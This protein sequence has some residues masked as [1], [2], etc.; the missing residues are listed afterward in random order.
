M[1]NKQQHLVCLYFNLL[2]ILHELIVECFVVQIFC[3]NEL[4][5]LNIWAADG[6]SWQ[7]ARNEKS[8]KQRV[9]RRLYNL[10]RRSLRFWHAFALKELILIKDAE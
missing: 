8:L 6:C 7:D 4:F 3:T 9:F 2:L 10:G 1:K 5:C